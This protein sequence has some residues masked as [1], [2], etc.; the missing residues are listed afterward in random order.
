M[1]VSEECHVCRV[2]DDD[3]SNVKIYIHRSVNPISRAWFCSYECVQAFKAHEYHPYFFMCVCLLYVY[4]HWM[5][6][7]FVDQEDRSVCAKCYWDGIFE[8]GQ[9]RSR[10]IQDAPINLTETRVYKRVVAAGFF[11]SV[12]LRADV[13]IGRLCDQ[14][15]PYDAAFRAKR[16]KHMMVFFKPGSYMREAKAAAYGFLL[17]VRRMNEHAQVFARFPIGVTKIIVRMVLASYNDF[18]WL[19]ARNQALY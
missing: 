6:P 7:I 10:M 3:K 19:E 5:D 12:S 9:K 11:E 1:R 4:R 17:V 13:E 18:V 2:A 8:R 14:F 15:Q 16:G